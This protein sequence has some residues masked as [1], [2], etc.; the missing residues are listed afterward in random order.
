MRFLVDANM[1]P[2]VA[3]RPR[4]EGHDAVAVRDIGLGDASDDEILD[5]AI[6]DE[7]VIVSHDTDRTLRGP[8]TSRTATRPAPALVTGQSAAGVAR[9]FAPSTRAKALERPLV[10][11]CRD[12]GGGKRHDP[13]ALCGTVWTR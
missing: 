4:A 6:E 7:R 3:E 5:L 12:G 13:S 10:R 8:H 11:A 1:S 2:W 9:D